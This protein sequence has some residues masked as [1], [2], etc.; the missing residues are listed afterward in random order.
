M[1][2]KILCL[3]TL[4]CVMLSIFPVSA[5]E[6]AVITITGQP[7][8]TI[9]Q[10]KGGRGRW[11]L[12]VYARV[13]TDAEMSYQWYLNTV[14][15]NHSGTPIP[16]ATK[17]VYEIP[18]DLD[19][20]TY[21]YYCRVSAP[22]AE[23]VYTNV[24][25]VTVKVQETRKAPPVPVLV[26]ITTDSITLKD[27]PNLEY[28]LDGKKW[29]GPVFTGLTP[30]TTYS[31]YARY[32][33]EFNYEPSPASEPLVV[34]TPKL[35]KDKGD[36][37]A[38]RLELLSKTGRS[39]TLKPIEGAE[40]SKDLKTW[41]D[42]NTF[43]NLSVSTQ[44]TFHARMKETD[45]LKSSPESSPL[46]VT[47]DASGGFAFV[48]GNRTDG[49]VRSDGGWAYIKTPDDVAFEPNYATGTVGLNRHIYLP[50][51]F[52]HLGDNKYYIYH[53]NGGYLS[54]KGTL[55]KDAEIIISEQPCVWLVY[56]QNAGGYIEYN[57]S[58]ASN[59]NYFIK[60]LSSGV[61]LAYS[62]SKSFQREGAQ[63]IIDT[64]GVVNDIPQWWKEYQARKT[65]PTYDV[66][67]IPT[68]EAAQRRNQPGGQ[69]PSGGT[70]SEP[71]PPEGTSEKTDP[72]VPPSN[73]PVTANPSDT[74]FVMN[75][76]RVS[77]TAAYVINGTNYLQ[78]RAIAS[79]LNGTAAQ[80]D[81]GW[82]GQYAVIE[83]GKPYSGTITETRLQSTT[84]VRIS[85]TKFKMNG[86]VFSFSDAR[87]IDGGTN[88]IQLREFAQKLS[89]T[90]SQFNVYWDS[91]AGQ[92]VIQPGL[93]YTGWP[94]IIESSDDAEASGKEYYY[95]RASKNENLVIEVAGASL[96]NGA[97]LSL[98]TRTGK[99]SQKFK[100]VHASGD[101][102]VIQCVHSGK[103]WTS[104][105]KKGTVLTQSTSATDNNAYSFRV[106]K[107]ADGTYRIMDNTG[108][109]VSVSDGKME[110][111]SNIV[112]STE[113]S[114]GSQTFILE[115][116]Q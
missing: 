12:K 92:A 14:N 25:K 63:F 80:F 74:K 24:S 116:T 35:Y 4:L 33:G 65:E 105:G 5:S 113:A 34:K 56:S 30:D 94:Q 104:S 96:E 83:P 108:L 51:Y 88:Y 66:E 78:I 70:S 45:D 103:L 53:A 100:L 36:Q 40:Y 68:Y 101:V 82:D 61:K 69:G 13:S 71:K 28:S 115:R 21:F 75:G 112:L 37:K 38:P 84:N 17:D 9:E 97:K 18:T 67:L 8:E 3:L 109:Y 39:V 99:D 50:F 55:N 26:S 43:Y 73:T 64:R 57:I 72:V 90:A 114:N 44:Y 76:S 102:Y 47:T 93:A 11:S 95:F 110:N 41:Q 16:G 42:S 27:D 111:G 6:A 31:V 23:P 48:P 98:G 7:Q 77:V 1:K 54:Y 59:T 19:G 87:L 106:I 32:I 60:V 29:R 91:D 20:G 81:I 10:I 107:Q 49:V 58:V 46:A 62:A 52:E 22:G 86:E 89:G 2:T 15:D 79:L 85:D